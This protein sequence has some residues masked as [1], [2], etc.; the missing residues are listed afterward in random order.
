MAIA[1]ILLLALSAPVTF[2][3]PLTIVIDNNQVAGTILYLALYTAEE[4]GGDWQQVPYHTVK[5]VLPMDETAEIQLDLPDGDYAARAYVDVNSNGVLDSGRS[6][7]PQEPFAISS[8]A[9]RGRP[10]LRFANAIFK[11][12]DTNNRIIMSLMYPKGA[13]PEAEASEE[14]AAEREPGVQ[15]NSEAASSNSDVN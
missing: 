10:S 12:D 7:R 14:A 1:I 8:P 13:A 5:R 15:Q 9:N 3:R 11:L 2:A 6:N 4:G